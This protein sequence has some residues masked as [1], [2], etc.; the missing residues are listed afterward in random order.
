MSLSSNWKTQVERWHVMR[1][2]IDKPVCVLV[3]VLASATMAHAE[4]RYVDAT[5]SGATDGTSW[6]DAFVHLQ[7]ALAVAQAGDE[8]WVAAGTYKPDQGAAQTPGDRT[9][10]FTMINGVAIYGGFAGGETDLAQRDPDA[11]VTIL[12]GDLLGDDI[13][14]LGAGLACYSTEN[15]TATS[16]CEA[17]FDVEPPGGDGDVDSA[18]LNIDDNTLR[19]VTGTATDSTAILDGF[20]ITAGNAD[21]FDVTQSAGGITLGSNAA[22]QVRNCVLRQNHGIRFGGAISSSGP[23]TLINCQFIENRAGEKGGAWNTSSGAATAQGCTFKRNVCNDTVSVFGWGGAVHSNN[24]EGL[25]IR[26]CVFEENNSKL[27]GGLYLRQGAPIIDDCDFER[28]TAGQTGTAIN[29]VNDCDA[30]ITRS[31]F[32]ENEGNPAI[33]VTA[34]RPVIQASNFIR[35]TC[36]S[37]GCA[38][39]TGVQQGDVEITLIDC[40][41]EENASSASFGGGGAVNFDGPLTHLVQGCRFTRNSAGDDGGAIRT[42]E[43]FGEPTVV[44]SNSVFE[45][46]IASTVANNGAGGAIRNEGSLTCVNSVFVGNRAIGLGVPNRSRGGAVLTDDSGGSFVN[47]IFIANEASEIDGGGAIQAG[48]SAPIGANCI[49]W[50]NTADGVLNHIR[51]LDLGLDALSYSIIQDIDP[52]DALI[53][54]DGA[55][56]NNLDDDPMFVRAPDPGP[57]GQWD[58]VDDD[59]GDL[60][61]ALGSPGLDAGNNAAISADDTDV[62]CDGNVF[63][64][65]PFDLNG[66]PRRVDDPASDSGNGIAPIVD[67]GAFERGPIDGLIV[68]VDADAAGA[69]DGSSWQDAFND[70]QDALD[71]AGGSI[72]G[73]IE[74]WV[75]EGTYKPDRGI[76]DRAATFQLRDNTGIFGGFDGNEM[77]IDERDPTTHVTILSGDLNGDDNAGTNIGDNSYHVVTGTGTTATAIL[78]GVTISGGNADAPTSG[79]GLITLGGGPTIRNSSLTDN[80]GECATAFESRGGIVNFEGLTFSNNYPAFAGTL[81]VSQSLVTLAGDLSIPDGQ[82]DVFESEFAGPGAI[83]LGVASLLK[84]KNVSACDAEL[85]ARSL[86]QLGATTVYSTVDLPEWRMP[87]ATLSEVFVL[88]AE[89]RWVIAPNWASPATLTWS[90]NVLASDLS[91]GGLAEAEFL[92]DGTLT[93]TGQ[94]YDDSD[95][96]SANLLH[97]GILLAAEV[98]AFRVRET[99]VDS[100]VLELV[101]PPELTP[102]GG[103]L[104]ENGLDFIVAGRQSLFLLMGPAQQDGGSLTSFDVASTIATS[105]ASQ[106]DLTPV[107]PPQGATFLRSRIIGTGQIEIDA[108]ASLVLADEGELNL[109]GQ[110]DP[111]CDGQDTPGTTVSGGTATVNGALV[112]QDDARVQ[113]TNVEVKGLCFEND[114]S[115]VH[116]DIRLRESSSG[117]GGEFFVADSAV[118]SCNNIISEGDRYLDLDPDPDDGQSPTIINNAI[119]V[120][121]K[122]GVNSIEGELLELRAVDHDNSLGGGESGHYQVVASDGYDDI[123]ALEKLEIEPG[124]KLT[125]TNRQGFVFQDPGITTPETL[126]VKDLILGDNSTLDLG[127]QRIYYQ[128][129]TQGLSSQ[130]ISTPLLGFSLVVIGME[131]DTEFDVRVRKRITD[132]SDVQ[133]NPPGLPKRGSIERVDDPMFGGIM[134]MKTRADGDF[135]TASSIAAHGAFARAAED[136]ILVT[137]EYLFCGTPNDELVVYL[138]DSPLASTTLV[139]IARVQPPAPGRAG[140]IGSGDF[141]RFVGSFPRGSL[142]FTRGTYVELELVGADACIKIDDWD[143]DVRCTEVCLDLSGDRGLS[144]QDFL[145]LLAEYGQEPEYSEWCLDNQELSAD[146]YVELTDLLSWDTFLNNPPAGTSCGLNVPP[147]SGT[148]AAPN[149]PANQ[150]IIAG[151]PSGAGLQEDFLYAADLTGQGVGAPARPASEASANGYRANTRLTKDADGELYQIHA[152][153]GLVRLSDAQV[154]IPPTSVTC[155][156]GTVP[157]CLNDDEVVIGV[158]PLNDGMGGYKGTPLLDVAFDRADP[159]IAFVAPVLI[160]PDNGS[161][162]YKAGAKLMLNPQPDGS[163]ALPTLLSIYGAN[164]AATSSVSGGCFLVPDPDKSR[165]REIE[166]DGQGNVYVL[167]AQA[168]NGNDWL[169]IFDD[170]SGAERLAVPLHGSIPQVLNPTS[171]HITNDGA[172]MYLAS[173]TNAQDATSVQVFRYAVDTVTPSIASN[174]TYDITGMRHVVSILE[175]STDDAYAVGFIAPVFGDLDT[176]DDTD[177]LFTTPVLAPLASTPGQVASTTISAG[178]LTLPISAVFS[179]NAICPRGDINDDGSV[180]LLDIAPFV[181]LV[182]DPSGATDVQQCT[183]DTNGDGQIDGNDVQGLVTQLAGP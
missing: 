109:S 134:E 19:I 95:Q 80:T 89:T 2:I 12:S 21:I 15:V 151:K 105:S 119:T 10:T 28:N 123:W 136:E 179:E 98:G 178:N 77:L 127:L 176:F 49:F 17:L 60:Q 9:A 62:D 167:S 25:S 86:G 84:I 70:L 83:D 53:P 65:M 170:T 113:N 78:D 50:D 165:V 14:E 41:F 55:V 74:I 52:D 16:A 168:I 1:T 142:N 169:L 47:C 180:S 33:Q 6:T 36:N 125:L 35:N 173:A 46:N 31:D 158:V 160:I 64:A 115:I 104:V 163:Y 94:L 177:A 181:A 42:T 141:A 139:E 5:A 27:G 147:V 120:I 37:G 153:Q 8:V 174:G 69:N 159:D 30:I 150:V 92:G 61:L 54:F 20:E 40:M 156:G 88:G 48:G 183:A 7:D 108:G 79:A 75:A 162:P 103:F 102:V 132:P 43:L 126:Y 71:F 34:G 72:C 22:A 145:Y 122:Q 63:E 38:I 87:S 137:F 100:N 111:G 182:L 97:D 101:E 106:F 116:N 144:N 81:G 51:G 18:D 73:A 107:N 45:G 114:N 143:P 68:F 110:A 140:S 24:G 58:G 155:V 135:D 121:I 76:G 39:S 124:A 171:M 3:I 138:S 161:C 133:P 57:D 148:G 129:L 56:N 11:N 66:N 4:V 130:I 91:D 32:I 128:T 166:I 90:G 131:S 112:V 29:L 146:Q 13:A 96:G 85:I 154:A 26:E 82:F 152:T 99:V 67:I 157:N 59:Y 164:P 23:I 93:I 117:F 44:I 172:T 149:L 118:L 175:D